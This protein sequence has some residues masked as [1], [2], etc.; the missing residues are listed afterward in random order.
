MVWG[1]DKLLE[2]ENEGGEDDGRELTRLVDEGKELPISNSNL[3][4]NVVVVTVVIPVLQVSLHM[5]H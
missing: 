5:L 2:R 4:S 1:K 3:K